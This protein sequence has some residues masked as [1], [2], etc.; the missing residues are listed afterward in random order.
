MT[1]NEHE[2]CYQNLTW[3]AEHHIDFTRIFAD[4]SGPSWTDRAFQFTDPDWMSVARDAVALADE[5]GIRFEWSI[6]A[7]PRKGYAPRQYYQ[8]CEQLAELIGERL[9]RVM[10]LEVR[11]E[12]EGPAN[13]TMLEC[14]RLLRQLRPEV[15]VAL[16]GTPEKELPQFYSGSAANLGTVHWERKYEERGYR[17]IRQPWG[18]YELHSMPRAHVN[19]EPIGIDSSIASESDPVK[20]AVGA[21]TSW[22]TGEGAYVLHHG[23]GIRAGGAADLARTPPRKAN[24]WEQ[25][26]LEQALALME[27]A[28]KLMNPSTPSWE[29][30]GH[31]WPSHPLELHSEIGDKVENEGAAGA[32]RAYAATQG[33]SGV[34]MVSGIHTRFRASDKNGRAWKVFVP[35]GY[36]WVEFTT[37]QSIDV[38]EQEASSALLI[39]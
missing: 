5:C 11:N 18:Y 14:A 26:T 16:C 35:R 15:A 4:V 13:E 1:R 3:L 32:N 21:M 30:H 39:R 12:Q 10:F 23:A 17:P 33:E 6:F 36:E 8:A 2:R 24:V 31:M 7:G 28:R 20:L 37:T 34:V 29:H 19:N 25:P 38:S 22:V 9:D 27:S